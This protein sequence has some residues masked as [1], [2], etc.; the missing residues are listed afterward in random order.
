MSCPR[1]GMRACF[2]VLGLAFVIVS[3]AVIP[4]RSQSAASPTSPAASTAP[5]DI[6]E[7]GIPVT[8]PLVISKCS[9]CHQKDTKSNLTRISWIRTTPEGWEEAIKR[10]IRLRGLTLTPDE[11]RKILRYLSDD[12]GLAPAEAQPVTYMAEQRM[13]DEKVPN[14]DIAHACKACHAFGKP[15]SWR[16]SQDDWK[17]LANMHIAFFPAVETT[18][19]QRPPH[20]PGSPPPPPGTDTRPP[21]DQAIDYLVKNG[22]LHSPEWADW[23]ASMRTPKLA[24]RW[25]VAG[26]QPGK[27]RFFGEMLVEAV[28]DGAVSTKT[29]I[30]FVR[31][32]TVF[33]STGT[34]FIYTGYAWRG[35]SSVHTPGSL[36]DSPQSVR[37]VMTVSRDQS[38]MEGRWFWGAYQ[39]F[40]LDVKL[41]RAAESPSVLGID[42][43][44]LQRGVTGAQVR[45]YG[46]RLP[47]DLAAGDL[48]F[49]SGVTVK[50]LVNRKADSVTAVVDVTANATPGRRDIAVRHAVAPNALAIY[51]RIDF[52]K[53]SPSTALAHLGSDVHAKGYWQFEAIGYSNGPDGQPNTADDIELGPVAAQWKMEEFVASYNDDDTEFVGALNGDTGLFVPAADGPNP[54]RRQSRNNYGDVWVVASI[55]PPRSDKTL[56]ARSYLVVAVPQYVRWDQPEVASAPVKVTEVHKR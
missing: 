47:A 18:S 27:G 4:A 22:S 8:E 31:D 39:E 34:A 30:N 52:I 45:I 20:R 40:G 44:S 24:G 21:M 10:M 29:K 46:D 19:F 9:G 5:K 53:V 28:A 48:D 11:A 12:H 54:K 17:L 51:D 49:G 15:L 26:T 35:R 2:G 37:E 42:V 7:E 36:I 32:G 3:G 55:K 25:L 50:K 16:R 43:P 13:I 56:T 41:R 14:D 1:Q 23:H 6:H 33:S 38:Q